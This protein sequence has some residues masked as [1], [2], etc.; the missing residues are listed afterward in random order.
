ERSFAPESW[1]TVADNLTRAR[2]LQN[3]SETRLEEATSA[4]ADEVQHY[5]RAAD[6]LKQVQEQQ[7]QAQGMLQAVGPSLQKPTEV[8]QGCYHRSQ[9]VAEQARRVQSFFG[10]NHTVVCQPARSKFDG[11]EAKWR[12]VRGQMDA[13]RPNWPAVQQQLDEAKQ[14]YVGALKDGE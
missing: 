6:F 2:E 7:E 9:D 1:S 14:A 11:A 12:Q 13:G 4:S 8:R 5:F 3:A 10:M